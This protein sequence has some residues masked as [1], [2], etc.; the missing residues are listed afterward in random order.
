[1]SGTQTATKPRVWNCSYLVALASFAM[2]VAGDLARAQPIQDPQSVERAAESFVHQAIPDG[3]Q[4]A[5]QVSATR[6][7]PRLRLPSC[8]T[9]LIAKWS[10]GAA[11]SARTSVVVACRGDAQWRINVPVRIR[12]AVDVLVLK[13]PAS[14][15]QT[16]A[17]ADVANRHI[18]V[19]GLAHLYVR[20][21]DELAGRHLARSVPAG[22]PLPKSWFAADKVV[23]RGQAVTLIA[24]ANGFRVRAPG[25]ALGDGAV[26]ERVRV[27]N[28]SSLKV[29]EGVVENASEVRVAP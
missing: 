10:A 20:N 27:Q 12:S 9:S 16:L 2:L 15:G 24:S 25:R 19:E 22:V 6:L 29:V 4:Q 5:V 21:L 23:K 3:L 17:A 14:R 7:D 18:E 8:A 1:A 13:A 11:L 26:E 28:L